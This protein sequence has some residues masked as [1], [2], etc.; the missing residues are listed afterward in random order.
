MVAVAGTLPII[1]KLQE[2]AQSPMKST[3]VIKELAQQLVLN[4]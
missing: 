2:L 3:D 4:S 1:Q